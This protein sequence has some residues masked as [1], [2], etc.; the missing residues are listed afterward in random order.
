MSR[1]KAPLRRIIERFTDEATAVECE[2]LECGHVL[3]RKQD[4]FGHTTAERRR[5]HKCR[6]G[7]PPAADSG[8]VGGPGGG[9]L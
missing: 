2:R 7:L 3:L 5:C 6:R 4:A 8:R 1:A 9:G